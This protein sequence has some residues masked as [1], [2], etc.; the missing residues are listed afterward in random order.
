MDFSESDLWT[1][2]RREDLR[3][4]RIL[5]RGGYPYSS[6]AVSLIQWDKTKAWLVNLR[7]VQSTTALFYTQIH[8]LWK[9]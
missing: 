7:H 9:Y 4:Q 1:T 2:K 5:G 6:Y 8:D 3:K